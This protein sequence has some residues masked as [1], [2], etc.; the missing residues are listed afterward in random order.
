METGDFVGNPEGLKWAGDTAAPVALA[1]EDITDTLGY[2]LYEY[3]QKQPGIKPPSVWFP[4]TLM[5]IST[6]D[7]LLIEDDRLGPFAGQLL[8]GDQGH[9][10]IMRVALEQVDGVYQGAVFGFREGF[11]SG[12]SIFLFRTSATSIEHLRN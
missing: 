6:S 9:S 4:H 5:G 1:Y 11:S 8:V 3:A 7:I 12:V 10:K 2:T